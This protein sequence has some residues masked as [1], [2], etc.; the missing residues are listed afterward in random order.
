MPSLESAAQRGSPETRIRERLLLALHFGHKEPGDRVPSVRTMARVTGVGR[1][2]VH[3]AYRRLAEEGLI[4]MRPGSGTFFAEGGV[5]ALR[6]SI[7]PLM[8]ALAALREQ[9]SSLDMSPEQLARILSFCSGAR[10][11]DSTLAIMECNREQ[12]GL[13]ARELEASLAAPLRPVLLEDLRADPLGVLDGCAGLVTTDC[14]R[15]EAETL[16][17]PLHVPVYRVALEERFTDAVIRCARKRRLVMVVSDRRYAGVLARMLER[18][19]VPDDVRRRVSVHEA[20]P[21][22]SLVAG[23]TNDDALYVSPLVARDEL[24]E[25][26]GRPRLLD[27]G[28]YL[29][30]P[31]IERLHAQVA[32]DASRRETRLRS[33]S[34]SA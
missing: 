22:R 17:R 13:I 16:C 19:G 34:R 24:P 5:R 32:A 29:Y 6:A 7:G 18:L 15:Q 28:R 20:R 1:K 9:A 3:R 25:P 2:A 12:Q 4:E 14:H 11:L 21:A 30:E 27:P 23:L 31:S 8:S 33:I 10:V 26:S